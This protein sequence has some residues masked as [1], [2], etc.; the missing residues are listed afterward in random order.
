MP[1]HEVQTPR[2]NAVQRSAVIA[3]GHTASRLRRS[4]AAS[5]HPFTLTSVAIFH[6]AAAWHGHSPLLRERSITKKHF[7]IVLGRC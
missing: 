6:V 4:V 7:F 5:A 3:E 2:P 1:R